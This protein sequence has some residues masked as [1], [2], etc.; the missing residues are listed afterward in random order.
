MTAART[1]RNP[2][3]AAAFETLI[4]LL[5]VTGMRGSEAMRLDDQDLDAAA[6]LLTIR[7]TKF[8]N[9]AEAVVMPS[10]VTGL[11]AGGS[12]AQDSSA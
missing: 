7:A 4:G 11:V 2:L 8:G 6:A 12:A 10:G 5:A 9:Y 1:L 3:K